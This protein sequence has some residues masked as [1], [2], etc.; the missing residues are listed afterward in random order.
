MPGK[1]APFSPSSLSRLAACPASWR[2]SQGVPEETSEYAKEGILAHEVA[3]KMLSPGESLEGIDISEEMLNAVK[4]YV[5]HVK[6]YVNSENIFM[7]EKRF[8]IVDNYCWG[9]AD[10]V[11]VEPLGVIR[12]FDLKYG[13]GNV[14]DPVNNWQC[15]AYLLGAMYGY[16]DCAPFMSAEIHIVQPRVSPEPK[17]WVVDDPQ[18][19]VREWHDKITETIHLCLQE[20]AAYNPGGCCQFCRARAKCPA[21]KEQALEI[22][23]NDFADNILALPDLETEELIKFHTRAKQVNIFL[24]AVGEELFKRAT[25]NQ[26]IQ[27][28]KLV[29]NTGNLA[30]VTEEEELIK[31]FRGKKLKQEDFSTRKLKT[32][33]QLKKLLG[34]KFVEEHAARPDKG[35]V[36]V[37]ESD[38]RQ[39]AELPNPQKEFDMLDDLF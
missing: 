29:K 12:V 1:H 6:K 38:K 3:E 7:V 10:A 30:W 11:V 2:A 25:N 27:G 37:H 31:K 9:T 22:A 36:L 34:E 33:T 16:T 19:F 28:Y 5:D 14:I 20:N 4:I 35:L 39:P 21:I 18:T 13:V 15:A 32:P 17:V 26:S 8:N 23:K 24:K